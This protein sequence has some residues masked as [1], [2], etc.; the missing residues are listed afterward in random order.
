M[1][2][3]YIFLFV[4]LQTILACG[5]T[6]NNTEQI[7]YPKPNGWVN[8]YENLFSESEE[9]TLDSLISDF[10]RKTS[11]EIVIISVDSTILQN[12]KLDS[13]ALHFANYWGVGKKDKNNG[14]LFCI[15]SQQRK[16][17][18]ENGLGIEKVLTN[19]KTKEIMDKNIIPYYKKMEYY[20]GTLE[21]LYAIM[22]GLEEVK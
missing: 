17:R 22:N 15:S 12:E 9:K 6:T 21:G 14:I 7:N 4:L 5:Q 1:K 11:N 3:K 8:D 20:K 10:E 18:I 13:F 16:I 19:E 2:T